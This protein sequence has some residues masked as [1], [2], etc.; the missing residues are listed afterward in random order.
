MD[1]AAADWLA[2]LEREYLASYIPAG[3]AA[4]KFAIAPTPTAADATRGAILTAA[5]T[6]GLHTASLD[7]ATVKLHLIEQIFFALARGVDWP[8]LARGRVRGF[9]E[10]YGFVV[11]PDPAAFTYEQIAAANAYTEAELRRDVRNWLRDHV[12]QD[13]AMVQEFRIAM[14]R[15]C[16]AQL[17]P[18]EAAQA[19]A[20]A[21]QDWLRGEL[22]LISALKPLRIF[23][24]IARHNARDMFGSLVHWLRGGGAAGLALVLDIDRYVSG[25]RPREPD[26]TLYHSLAATLD[27]YEVLRQFIDTTDE[28]ACCLIVVLA[29]PAF[30]E[31]ERRGLMRYDALR[32]RVWDEV[33]DRR[34]ANP[35]SALVRLTVA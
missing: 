27:V 20:A 4:V 24:K 25:Q 28:L 16:Q 10:R 6:H 19:E 35:L 21:L 22:R 18:G 26:G 1:V 29:P 31:D 34:R 30:L 14:L 32:L 11:P 17:D 12:Y 8:A 5:R 23:Q 9:L 2:L 13:Y 33:R 3:G 7:A 15:L